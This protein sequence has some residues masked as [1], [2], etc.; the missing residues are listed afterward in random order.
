MLKRTVTGIHQR[1][2]FSDDSDVC[3]HSYTLCCAMIEYMLSRMRNQSLPLHTLQENTD[4]YR[5]LYDLGFH[6]YICHVD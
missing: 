5:K 1:G 4:G 2:G 3:L 6:F